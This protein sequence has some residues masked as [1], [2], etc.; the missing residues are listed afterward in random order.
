[1][2]SEST[3]CKGVGPSAPQQDAQTQGQGQAP[4]GSS[5]CDTGQRHMGDG[6]GC[7]AP[8]FGSCTTSCSTGAKSASW[9]SLICSVG[10]LLRWTRA[11]RTGLRTS[12]GRWIGRQPSPAIPALSGSTMGL[13]SCRV[14]WIYGPSSTA[15]PWT[16]AG[17]ASPLTMPSPSPST[18]RSGLNA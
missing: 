1:M 9:R 2:E 12:S 7:F 16:S 5:G 18:V 17:R 4:G 14:T 8:P 10:S 3:S 6:I 15:S 13:S 11:S